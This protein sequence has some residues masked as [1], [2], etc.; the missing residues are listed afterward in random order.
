MLRYTPPKSRQWG[1][2]CS[3][4]SAA[5]L[6]AKVNLFLHENV[7]I[8]ASNSYQSLQLVWKS[9]PDDSITDTVNSIRQSLSPPSEVVEVPEPS[10]ITLVALKLAGQAWTGPSGTMT[11]RF[12]WTLTDEQLPIVAQWLD[13]S[14][15]ILKRHKAA[16]YAHKHVGYTWLS[17][18]RGNHAEIADKNIFGVSLA[19]PRS[20]SCPIYFYDA[21]HYLRI[22]RY[23]HDIGLANLSDKHI[24]PGAQSPAIMRNR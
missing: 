2:A 19:R 23:M 7:H 17:H 14:E 24:R 3:R 16:A 13:Q 9:A 21:E 11:K 8:E 12:E 22:K 18:H 6:L 4:M 15:D 5:E 20:I 10:P 1:H